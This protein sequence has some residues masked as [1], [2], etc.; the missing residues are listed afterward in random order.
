MLLWR[1]EQ[2]S[3]YDVIVI[4]LG[5]MGGAA[6]YHSSKRGARVLGLDANAFGHQLG[7]SHGATRA[8]RE[9]YF[10]APDYV[11]LVQRSFAMWRELERDSGKPLLSVNGAVYVAPRDHKMLEGVMSSAEQHGIAVERLCSREANRRFPG[12]AVPDG[13]EAVFE[14]HGGVLQAFDCQKAHI[15]L[16][17]SLGASL[18][19]GEAVRSWTR[20]GGDFVVS[21][22]HER[23]TAPK[24]ILTPGPWTCELLA[25]LALPLSVRRIP[26]IHFEPRDPLRYDSG[27]MSVYFWATPEGIYAGFPH[28]DGEGVKVMRHD[29]CETCTPSTARRDIDAGDIGEVARFADKCLPFANGGV[30]RTSAC[31]Y[32]M[33]PDSHFVID[34]HPE[35]PGLVYAS[36]CSGHGFKFAPVV[37]EV[38]AELA[39]EGSTDKPIG[40]LSAGRF[41]ALRRNQPENFQE[42]RRTGDSLMN[43]S[44][45]YTNFTDVRAP[46]R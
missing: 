12:F 24:L 6:A 21:T 17:Q 33:T 31:L 14:S 44:H 10:E 35:F 1:V 2:M 5:V 42:K 9:T 41:G 40:F 20:D 36:A 28:F 16:A 27:T 19:F 32:T 11:P 39:L 43:H 7:S 18:R 46:S 25:D 8:I 15:D 13:W 29:R 23:Y 22:D 45:L 4:G 3:A 26:V 38:L 30:N 37:G 34:R